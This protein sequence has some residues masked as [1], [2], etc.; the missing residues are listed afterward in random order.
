ML[1]PLLD[2][3]I[4]ALPP[5]LTLTMQ[6]VLGVLVGPVGL[7]VATPM[8]AAGVVLTRMLYVEDV[9]GDRGSGE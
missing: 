5:G 4:I 3:K 2:R 1:D 9:L 6:I 8:T 7:A